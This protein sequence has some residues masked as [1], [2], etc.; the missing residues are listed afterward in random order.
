MAE[1]LKDVYSPSFLKKLSLS[2]K[3]K[4]KNFDEN[5][6]V[7]TVTAYPWKALG[8]KV[9]MTRIADGLYQQ[10]PKDFS[11]A[12][13]LLLKVAPEFTG[14]SGLIFPHYVELYADRKKNRLLALK[15]LLELTEY[16]SSEF[17]IRPFIIDQPQKM[18]QFMLDL[19]SH[20]NEHIRRLASEGI[21]PRLPWGQALHYF[22]KDPTLLLPILSALKNDDS[23][24][25][26]KSVANHL[27]DICKDNPK[28]IIEL[29]QRWMN[30]HPTVHTQWIV[31]QGLRSLVKSGDVQALKILG[32]KPQKNVQLKKMSLKRK[33]VPMNQ[34]L[35]FEFEL[36]NES[37]T[38]KP[39][40]IDYII[41]HQ[42]S[43]GQLQPK[44]FKLT[45]KQIGGHEGLTFK[46]K[47]SFRLITTRKYYRGKHALSILIN[48]Q[49]SSLNYFELLIN[50]GL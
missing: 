27:N 14:L 41:Y 42:K 9:R 28:V 40:I 37:S 32:F 22:K 16:S 29:T 43:N 50:E 15:A 47:H 11:K 44:V 4:L 35:E 3:K 18:A 6:F 8:L 2:F 20:K 21:R 12:C 48:G 5:L 30:N 7:K 31:K 1:L 39:L 49:E 24:Y 17:A 10:L 13:P 23:L 19:T 38:A 46:K 26:R 36:V 45:Q 34:A 33:I 25:V